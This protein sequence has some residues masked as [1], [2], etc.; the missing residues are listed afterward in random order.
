MRGPYG[1]GEIWLMPNAKP[2]SVPP[3]HLTGESRD[4]LDQLVGKCVEQGKLEPGRGAWNTPAFPVPKTV[5]GTYRLVQDLRPQNAATVKDG[6]P[7]PRIGYMVFRQGKN[8][9][10]TVLD[11]VDG[12]HQMPNEGRASPSHLHEYSTWYPP[13]DCASD[14]FEKMRPPNSSA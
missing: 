8:R 2:V 5:P 4:A 7:L 6:H 13:V 11:L 3:F 12:F 14:G 9:I 1:E 10:W